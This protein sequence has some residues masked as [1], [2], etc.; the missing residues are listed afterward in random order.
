MNKMYVLISKEQY[1]GMI[2]TIDILSNQTLTKDL[3]KRLRKK[4]D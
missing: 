2:E 4:S 1:D 3:L